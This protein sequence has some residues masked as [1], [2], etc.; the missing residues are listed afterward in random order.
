MWTALDLGVSSN[1]DYATHSPLNLIRYFDTQ[2]RKPLQRVYPQNRFNVSAVVD[3]NAHTNLRLMYQCT[4]M[5]QMLTVRKH[6]TSMT[7]IVR[8]GQASHRYHLVPHVLSQARSLTRVN[9]NSRL[10]KVG[11]PSWSVPFLKWAFGRYKFC[12][13]NIQKIILTVS[14]F[15][16]A[17]G[18]HALWLLQA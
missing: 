5:R 17:S 11:P 6:F 13:T 10:R 9:I 16:H 18:C 15:R 7:V 4:D 2:T 3:C 8:R 12:Q 14:R 1:D